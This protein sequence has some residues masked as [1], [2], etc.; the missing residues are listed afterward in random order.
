M[1]GWSSRALA[2]APDAIAA[3]QQVI[4]VIPEALQA[5]SSSPQTTSDV[6]SA[7]GDDRAVQ[8]RSIVSGSGSRDQE[9]ERDE[10]G[11]DARRKAAVLSAPNP[12]GIAAG[13]GRAAAIGALSVPQRWLDDTEHDSDANDGYDWFRLPLRLVDATGAQGGRRTQRTQV[14]GPRGDE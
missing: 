10:Q 6:P 14:S 13:S 7:S 8:S 2:S 4:V 3:G 12:S 5:L 1:F 11:T 9:S